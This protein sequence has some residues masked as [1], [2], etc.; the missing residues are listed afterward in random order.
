MAK[1]KPASGRSVGKINQA[2]TFSIMNILFVGGTGI[3]SSGCVELAR[4]M[5]LNLTLLNRG[6]QKDKLEDV[7]YL[8]ADINNLAQCQKVLKNKY[9]D[10]V[11]DFVCYNKKD[12]DRDLLLFK[13]NTGHYIFISSASAYLAPFPVFPITEDAPLGNPVWEYSR[14]KIACEEKLLEAVRDKN[15][16]GTI[17]RPSHTYGKTYIPMHG[18]YT[19]LDRMQKGLPIVVH[20]DGTSLWALTH[21]LDFAQGLLGLFGKQKAIGEAYHITTDELLNWDEIH[22]QFAREL[23]LNPEI[24]HIA[25]DVIAK[26]DAEWGESLLGDKAYSVIFDNSKIKKIVPHYK[27][28]IPFSEGVKE[29]VNWHMENPGL[30]KVDTSWNNTVEKLILDWHKAFKGK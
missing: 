19:V 13:E 4:Q 18:G 12:M 30:Q 7:N 1:I 5:G 29:I 15:F 21:H 27:A 2:L 25:S 22:M 24:I 6:N 16:P 14:N 10:V 26:Y 23:N 17:V 28:K 8:V 3:I 20:G 11:V 9:F